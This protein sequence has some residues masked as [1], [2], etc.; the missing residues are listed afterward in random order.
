VAEDEVGGDGPAGRVG[1][2]VRAALALAVLS[3]VL[4][5]VFGAL[6]VRTDGQVDKVRR[7]LDSQRGEQYRIGGQTD[8]R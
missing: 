5:V 8:S 3:A 6:I 7:E 1:I 4:V 2:L